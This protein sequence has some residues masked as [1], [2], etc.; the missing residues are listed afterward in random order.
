MINALRRWWYGPS[1]LPERVYR[2]AVV[3]KREIGVPCRLFDLTP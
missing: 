2:M 1:V 3:S